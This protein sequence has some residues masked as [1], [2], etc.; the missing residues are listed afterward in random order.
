MAN[1]GESIP[2]LVDY[3]MEPCST[4]S[5]IISFRSR[6]NSQST[7]V[8]S[9][10]LTWSDI[11]VRPSLK[12]KQKSQVESGLDYLQRSISHEEGKK[13][14]IPPRRGFILKDV[15]GI[16]E[17]GE[18][19]ALMGA[20]G[21]GKT[22]L[23]NV[24]T[25]RNLADLEVSGSI[26]INGRPI[27]RTRLRQI[28]AY[29]QQDEMFIPTLTVKEHLSFMA[30][31]KMGK[32]H[33][34]KEQKRRVQAALNDLELD[35]C[36]DTV[37]GNPLYEKSLSGGE[38]KR[39]SFAS[40]ILTSPPI[41]F[42]D[43]PTSGLDSFMAKQVVQI[44][45]RLAH[46]KRMTII[47]T[48]HQPA[49]QVYS[50]FDKLCLMAEGRVVFTG[51]TSLA[52]TLFDEWGFP[53]PMNFNPADHYIST[54]A[55]KY[56]NEGLCR[57]RVNKLCDNFLA[58]SRGK[59]VLE[60][61][62]GGTDDRRS[63]VSSYYGAEDRTGY[64]AT[65]PQQLS[66]LLRRSFKG[67]TREPE[68]FKF[69]L[70]ETLLVGLII[71]SV[72]FQTPVNQSTITNINGL[73][74]TSVTNMNFMYQFEAVNFFCLE[75]PIFMREHHSGLYR[76]DA[77]FLAKNL[78]ELPQ[79]LIFPFSFCTL[80]Y[81]MSGLDK[82]LG[83]Y[84]IYSLIGVLVANIGVSFSYFISCVFGSVRLSMALLPMFVVP[85]TTFGGFY[86]N[87]DTI[88]VY[89]LP[90]RYISYFNYA[91]E[92]MT[93][94]E[95]SRVDHIGGCRANSTGH[96]YENGEDVIASLSYN[97]SNL[98][99]NLFVMVAMIVILRTLAFSA[100]YIRAWRHK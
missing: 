100:L 33:S 17:P 45:K 81:W 42:C 13:V 27:S 68:L 57:S 65:Y 15:F 21:A 73:L 48:I 83:A 12:S 1:R 74:Y 36:K 9:T 50:V 53:L 39:L 98:P 91:F 38:R 6:K 25:M 37:I 29:C 47:F 62:D 75:L 43:E 22:T 55:I 69:R 95:W 90:L 71:G 10:T 54:L 16:A 44:L 31:L 84:A 11:C 85:L 67:I 72:Y 40:E 26:Q 5:S 64:K 66:V 92:T 78:A 60:L 18:I 24:L 7:V 87:T 52:E 89:F 88:P 8:P 3:E 93:I 63:T 97:E 76:V 23:L 35:K 96:C 41:L 82:S 99:R 4:E 51:P 77:Y 59:E 56:S 79:Y 61:C 58:C 28:S 94:N 32:T 80:V 19:L 34:S 86:V 20:S 49:S 14:K 46:R 70:I 30:A 2:I